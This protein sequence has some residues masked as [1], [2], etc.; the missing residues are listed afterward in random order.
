MEFL[1]YLAHGILL[2]LTLEKAGRKGELEHTNLKL[3]T[4]F[5]QF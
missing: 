4:F 2:W 3:E 1:I 5:A